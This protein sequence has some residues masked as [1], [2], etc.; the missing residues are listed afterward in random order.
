MCSNSRYCFRDYHLVSATPLP[1]TPL[2]AVSQ[3]KELKSQLGEL[4]DAFVNLSQQNMELASDL[5]TARHRC[6]QLE[7]LLHEAQDTHTDR[8]THM[9]TEVEMVTAWRQGE[10]QVGNN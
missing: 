9:E 6:G 10:E 7:R 4:Q 3:N 2:R 1:P 8:R 5:Q